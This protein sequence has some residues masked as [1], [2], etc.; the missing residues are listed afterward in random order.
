MRRLAE[1]VRTHAESSDNAENR[2]RWQKLNDLEYDGPPLILVSP[3]GAWVE[4]AEGFDFQCDG[5]LA[6]NWENQLLQTLYKQQVV[7]DDSTCSASFDINW[8]AAQGDFGFAERQ[9]RSVT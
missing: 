3:E 2:P 1:R 4:I 8:R 5:E 6:R 7:A 9:R